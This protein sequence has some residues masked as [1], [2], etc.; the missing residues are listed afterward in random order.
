MHTASIPGEIRAPTKLRPTQSEEIIKVFAGYSR[1][2][3]IET[4]SNLCNNELLVEDEAKRKDAQKQVTPNGKFD[5]LGAEVTLGQ[6]L[7]VVKLQVKHNVCSRV[8]HLLR[9]HGNLYLLPVDG[10]N[11]FQ[12]PNHVIEVASTLGG[13]VKYHSLGALAFAY[14]G[15]GAHLRVAEPKILV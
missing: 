7:P 15:R 8:L 6:H 14:E 3:L 12:L 10:A 11:R 13:I 1:E 2:D 4:V 9:H 5:G